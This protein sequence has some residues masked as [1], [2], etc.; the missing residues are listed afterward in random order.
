MLIKPGDALASRLTN[1]TAN[2]NLVD[3]SKCHVLFLYVRYYLFMLCA[4]ACYLLSWNLPSYGEKS[5]RRN[6]YHGRLQFGIVNWLVGRRNVT[7]HARRLQLD[8][9]V[10]NCSDWIC[11][12]NQS[13]V[14]FQLHESD[15]FRCPWKFP[16]NRNPIWSNCLVSL[17]RSIA[18]VCICARDV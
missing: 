3:N 16:I 4:P 10:I 15:W 2:Y 7:L 14:K 18:R 11:F 12:R 8:S 6:S 13:S 9:Y 17:R 5:A 1:R